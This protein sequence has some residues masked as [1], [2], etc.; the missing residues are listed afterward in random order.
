MPL[1]IWRFG[2]LLLGSL[3][4]PTSLYR[5]VVTRVQC[6]NNWV[7]R[8]PIG[9]QDFPSLRQESCVYVDKTALIKRLLESGTYFFLSRPRRFGKSLL[10]STIQAIFEGRKD[11]FVGLWLEH[12]YDFAVHPIIRLD[13]S[14]LDFE[15][16][17]LEV[18]VIQELKFI[19]LGYGLELVQDTV[20]SVFEELIRKLAATTKVVV[21][22]DE[23]DKPITD[24][25]L[26]IDKRD[27]HVAVL[28][29]LYGV[30]KPMNQ[31]LE[32][33]MLT[34]VSKIGKLSLFS[35]L[36]NL[37]DI[38]LDAE[39][40]SLCGY[41]REEIEHNFSDYLLELAQY[42]NLDLETLWS[43]TKRWY[44]GYSWDGINRLYCPFSFLLFLKQKEF[45]SYWYQTATPTFLLELIQTQQLNPLE[46][47]LLQTDDR[48]LQATSLDLLDPTSLMFQTGYLTI[49]QKHRSPL[50]V[51][52]D[53]SFPNFEVRY[54]F[55][56]S[57]LGYYSH[58][59]GNQISSFVIDLR[60]ALNRLDWDAFFAKVNQILASIPYEIFPQQEAYPHSLLHLMLVATGY[61]TTSQVQT[62]LGRMDILLETFTHHIIF[63]LKTKGTPKKAVTQINRKQYAAQ[64][65][66]PV[67]KVGVIF[68]LEQKV[69]SAWQ[70]G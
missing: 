64:F 50:G 32:F 9:I 52:Y 44:N 14:K 49:I 60:S 69:F 38:S 66:T 11:L 12:N 35:D 41:S 57:L 7:Q 51:Q 5:A 24:Y 27:T 6:Y 46:F 40:A 29:S 3:S 58:W 10:L 36:N 42:Q 23:Y 54:A 47:E 55:S 18:S 17:S 37:Q 25:L 68:N 26:E 19:A 61:Q 28:R 34:G 62:S 1:C 59:V 53:L 67:I 4:R 20:R 15:A 22:I 31:Y 43:E 16:R 70:V 56:R 13:F 65:A 39:F 45:M 2:W 48:P 63:E 8:L 21:L 33:V 30:L